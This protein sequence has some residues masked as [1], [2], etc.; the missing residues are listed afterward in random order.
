MPNI[1]ILY[2]LTESLNLLLKKLN[3]IVFDLNPLFFEHLLC[4]FLK[5]ILL[6]FV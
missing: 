6:K 5:N 1:V 4:I 3:F 2:D